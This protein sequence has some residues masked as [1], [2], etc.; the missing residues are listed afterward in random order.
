MKKYKDHDIFT[1]DKNASGMK[2][3]TR[4]SKGILRADTLQGIK[5]LINEELTQ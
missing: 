1:C 4:T 5:I 3:Y 2:Y